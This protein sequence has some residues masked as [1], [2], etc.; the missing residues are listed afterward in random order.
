MYYVVLLRPASDHIVSVVCEWYS[1]RGGMVVLL[2][3]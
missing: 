3:Q 2:V 1:V